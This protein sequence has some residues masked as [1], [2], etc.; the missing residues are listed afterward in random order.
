MEYTFGAGPVRFTKRLDVGNEGK[1]KKE[2][3]LSGWCRFLSGGRAE[4]KCI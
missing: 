4:G 1:K 3:L 2:K